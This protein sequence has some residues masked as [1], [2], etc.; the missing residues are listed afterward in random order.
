[1]IL[2]NKTKWSFYH[3]MVPESRT[4]FFEQ[5]KTPWEIKNKQLF[6]IVFHGRFKVLEITVCKKYKCACLFL[7][8]FLW[9]STSSTLSPKIPTKIGKLAKKYLPIGNMANKNSG[10]FLCYTVRCPGDFGTNGEVSPVFRDNGD[11]G[12]WRLN[13]GKIIVF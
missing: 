13:Q 5:L 11:S 2:L 12:A 8:C 10:I 4:L 6:V 7:I 9:W 1:M 3:L